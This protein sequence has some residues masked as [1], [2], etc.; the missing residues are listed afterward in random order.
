MI[1]VS[2]IYLRVIC[3]TERQICIVHVIVNNIKGLI[4][5]TDGTMEVYVSAMESP[6]KFWVQI[7]GRGTTALDKLVSE[8]TAYYNETENREL[9]KLKDVSVYKT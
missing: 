4:S 3:H 6:T 9:H 7:V 5:G 8:M 2:L 1:R